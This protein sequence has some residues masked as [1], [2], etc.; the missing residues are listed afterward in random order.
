MVHVCW[1][2]PA[3]QLWW[4]TA[5]LQYCRARL[6]PQ[7]TILNKIIMLGA[8]TTNNIL[9]HTS[10]VQGRGSGYSFLVAFWTSFLHSLPSCPFPLQLPSIPAFLFSRSPPI[11]IAVSLFSSCLPLRMHL[12]SLSG[13]LMPF[14]QLSLRTLAGSPPFAA[15]SQPQLINCIS[16]RQSSK[17]NVKI[18]IAMSDYLMSIKC[19]AQ[20]K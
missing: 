15:L 20:Q 10:F 9:H 1:L 14:S 2:W 17:S 12:L 5:N 8:L 7:V 4:W 18:H 11:S 16:I 6:H 3:R 19:G 13:D